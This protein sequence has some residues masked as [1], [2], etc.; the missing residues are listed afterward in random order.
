[1]SKEDIVAK[2]HSEGAMF[3]EVDLQPEEKEL[4][5]AIDATLIEKKAPPPPPRRTVSTPAKKPA[6][7]AKKGKR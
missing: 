3:K 7:P 6:A 1:M 4:L 2:L 5:E